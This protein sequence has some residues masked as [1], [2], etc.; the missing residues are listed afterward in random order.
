MHDTLPPSSVLHQLRGEALYRQRRIAAAEASFAQALAQGAE[1]ESMAQSR[2]MCAMLRGDFESAWRISD[3]VLAAR[4]G[5]DCAH[6]PHHLRWVWDGTPLAGRRVLV[7]CY[8]G[9]GDTLQFIRL[10]PLLKQICPF[11][12][13]EAQPELLPLLASAPGVD[14]LVPLDGAVPPHDVAIESM[15]LPHALRLTLAAVPTEVPY[16]AVPPALVGAARRHVAAA[17][18]RLK[19]GIAWAAGAWKPERSVP[20]AQLIQL[21]ALPHIAL[22]NLQ[23]GPALAAADALQFA[24]REGESDDILETAALVT[25]LD[26]IVTI[27]TMVAHLAGALGRPVW[28]LLHYEADWRWMLARE[29]SPWYPT[30]RLF[31]QTSPGAWQPVIDRIVAALARMRPQG[32]TFDC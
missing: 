22:Y 10:A 9:L 3:A 17:D 21:N 23:R 24:T 31:R 27:D 13:I 19:V 7:R 30:M 1:P 14:A 32:V 20:S 16:L 12:A 26:V 6:L 18:G 28:T 8:H 29:D 15:E 2:W 4:A 11:V 5:R 25:H